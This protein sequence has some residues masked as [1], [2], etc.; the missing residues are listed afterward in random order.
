MMQNLIT[1]RN[2]DIARAFEE[3][4][5]ILEFEN[6]NP[7]RI[8]AYR[9]AARFIF[10]HNQELA[11]MVL[12][13][14]DLTEL[15]G[16]GKDLAHQIIQIV[17]EGVAARL[18]PL[19]ARVPGNL[20]A[21]LKI[22]GLGPKKVRRLIGVLGIK[23]VEDLA[24]ACRQ[25]KVKEL[26]GFGE[27]TQK[28]L[29]QLIEA[30]VE[31]SKR[32]K[33]SIA[34]NCALPLLA[35]LKEIKGVLK[36]EI[37]GSFRRGEDT[38]GDIDI[39]ICASKGSPV[40]QKFVS[41]PLVEE[42]LSQGPKRATIVLK[43]GMQ[44]DLRVVQESSFGAALVYFTG[45]KAHNISL[46][47]I[48]HDTGLKIN[49][50]G[51]WKNNISIGGKTEE[52]V[53]ASLGLTYIEPEL[54]EN[55][56]EIEASRLN[57]LPDLV[58]VS[59]L[60]GDLHSH[61]KASDGRYSLLQM[62]EAAQDF[63][64]QYLAICDHSKYLSIAHGLTQEEILAQIK[65]IDQINDKLGKLFLLKGIEV[66][67]L[68]DGSLDMPDD[69][70]KQLDVV[71]CSIHSHFG[72]SRGDQTKRLKKAMNNPYF[73][74]LGHPSGRLLLERQPYDLDMEEILSHAG[75]RGVCLELNSQP[76][77]LDLKDI[78]CRM[79][80]EAN[81]PIV[82]NSDSHS[83]SDFQ[84]LRFGIGQARRGWL[85]PKDILNTRPLREALDFFKAKS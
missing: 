2:S 20:T 76:D 25:D 47:T 81:V 64:L 39:L 5:D 50:Y 26:S 52:S 12:S 15:P 61:T 84:N 35:Y 1:I 51:V 36:A 32:F 53:Y 65:E 42:I 38:V 58:R 78:Y 66:D 18:A 69:I 7:F 21:L 67:I 60:K 28:R 80:K 56:G 23:S 79:A 57:K 33:L 14:E 63:G 45:S 11:K 83:V 22:P 46:R 44:V 37:A 68:A 41:Y 55:R 43:S 6:A 29:L 10:S 17:K 31:N 82:I 19:R 73:H 49:E 48:A 27:R 71:V 70:L 8:R 75:K 30:H 13:G 85:E 74:I 40:V 72:M 62:A 54:R 77:R 3:I 16:I 59:D 24:L 4:A 34:Q 9:N